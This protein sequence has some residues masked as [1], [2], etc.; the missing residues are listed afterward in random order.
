[1]GNGKPCECREGCDINA[2]GIDVGN[3]CVTF[4]STPTVRGCSERFR[5]LTIPKSYYSDIEDL[6][7]KIG[8]SGMRMMLRSMLLKGFERY[9]I[10]GGSVSVTQ[11]VHKASFVSVRW[12]HLHTFCDGGTVD[13]LPSEHSSFCS[14]MSNTLNASNISLH[15]ATLV[16]NGLQ[17]EMLHA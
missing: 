3:E 16:E 6:R 12:L 7:R 4:P 1:M 10:R 8:Q 15:W 9:R 5:I 14:V 11:C 17:S 2:T 13:G